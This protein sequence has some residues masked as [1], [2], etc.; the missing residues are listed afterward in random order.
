MRAAPIALAVFILVAAF[1]GYLFVYSSQLPQTKEVNTNLMAYTQRESFT[2]AQLTRA[3]PALNST[4]FATGQ[5][6]I[7][8][9]LTQEMNVTFAYSLVT[10]VAAR[11]NL[12]VQYQV[13]LGT[14]DWNV[15]LNS[16]PPSA[17][18]VQGVLTSTTHTFELNITNI[19]ASIK[20]IQPTT[21]YFSS[22]YTLQVK[23]EL[24]GQISPQGAPS[25]SATISLSPALNMT[26][27]NGIISLNGTSYSSTGAISGTSPAP[28]E[29]AKLYKN[30]SYV[31][32][33]AGLAGT[34][35]SGSLTFR[36]QRRRDAEKELEA[37]ASFYQEAIAEVSG[38]P[39]AA[40]HV[41]VSTLTDLVKVSDTLGKPILRWRIAS[42][43]LTEHHYYVLDGQTA[44]R[45]EVI[46][47]K[48][49]Q[50]LGAEKSD[51]PA[52]PESAA[53]ASSDSVGETR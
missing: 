5:G 51:L 20:K 32:M 37:E 39:E 47:P 43:E 52:E 13:L 34:G 1:G 2:H 30:V 28:N 25:S 16:V 10:S 4:I 44:Y 53:P 42:K 9:N 45:F 46:I 11:G 23:P 19:A 7:F 29:Q 31:V 33:V 14:K 48:E 8:E 18:P 21:G 22:A 50:P 24:E 3:S 38:P 26:L 49:A 27:S 17:L 41:D 36:R 40:N 12:S 15:S 6:P 35:V